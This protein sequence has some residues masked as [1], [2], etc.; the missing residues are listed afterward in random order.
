MN[1][2]SCLCHCYFDIDSCPNLTLNQSRTL[3]LEHCVSLE[4]IHVFLKER[5]LYAWKQRQVCKQTDSEIQCSC[6]VDIHDFSTGNSRGEWGWVVA[7]DLLEQRSPAIPC[8]IRQGAHSCT[9]R[10][11]SAYLMVDTG[12]IFPHWLQTLACFMQG[13]RSF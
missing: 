10:M 1:L 4:R 3:T 7:E 2:W 9:E 11:M 13:F 12:L 5:S 8:L 6:Q